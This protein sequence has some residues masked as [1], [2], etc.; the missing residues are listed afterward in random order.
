MNSSSVIHTKSFS[1]SSILPVKKDQNDIISHLN[2]SR[3]LLK[4]T[5]LQLPLIWFNLHE[6]KQFSPKNVK[7]SHLLRTHVSTL[8]PELLNMVPTILTYVTSVYFSI[9]SFFYW[10]TSHSLSPTIKSALLGHGHFHKSFLVFLY[11]PADFY[12]SVA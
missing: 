11:L 6:P 7:L 1:F 2:Y 9:R 10:P 5:V 4:Y 8:K 12:S 3:S